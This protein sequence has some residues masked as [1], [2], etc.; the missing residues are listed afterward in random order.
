MCSSAV[1]YTFSTP[2]PFRFFAVLC[3]SMLL[4]G[5]SQALP[6]P[7]SGNLLVRLLAP[8]STQ[9]NR[10]GDLISARV[11]LPSGGQDAILEG[12]IREVSDGGRAR[13]S[14][15][16]QFE[17]CVLHLSNQSVPIIGIVQQVTNSR[18]LAGVDEEGAS[19]EVI[20]RGGAKLPSLTSMFSHSSVGPIQ[21]STRASHLSF[22]PGSG[23]TVRIESRPS[24]N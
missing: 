12:E 11:L 9:F 7:F 13:K 8:V 10:K 16:I 18:G 17:F 5:Q 4:R 24:R 1:R 19:V 14:S 21:I 22:A 6:E 2:G 15:R 20:S 3:L 23:W